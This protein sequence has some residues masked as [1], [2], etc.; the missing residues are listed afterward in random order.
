MGPARPPAAALVFPPPWQT[1][2]QRSRFA[3]GPAFRWLHLLQLLHAERDVTWRWIPLPPQD[4][5]ISRLIIGLELKGLAEGNSMLTIPAARHLCCLSQWPRAI[6]VALN[7]QTLEGHNL[8]ALP[9][10]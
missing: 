2:L 5:V 1:R 9:P 4:I 3:A 7:I 8:G 10:P 6:T